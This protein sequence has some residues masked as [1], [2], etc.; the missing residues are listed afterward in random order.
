[1]KVRHCM[2]SLWIW[3]RYWLMIKHIKL[4]VQP[5]RKSSAYLLS[6]VYWQDDK[7]KCKIETRS[8][9]LCGWDCQVVRKATGSIAPW[10]DE[11]KIILLLLSSLIVPALVVFFLSEG[12]VHKND[13]HNSKNQSRKLRSFPYQHLENPSILN[14]KIFSS[15]NIFRLNPETKFTVHC[16]PGA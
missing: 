9:L 16:I 2:S 6:Y 10:A 8:K 13:L 4:F 5:K 15:H 12:K 11:T 14:N 1:M 7:C 3:N